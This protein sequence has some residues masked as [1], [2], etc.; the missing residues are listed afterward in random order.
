MSITPDRLEALAARLRPVFQKHT[1]LRAL[2]FGSWLAMKNRAGATSICWS[3][4]KQKNGS[5]TVTTTFWPRLPGL[6]RAGML[7]CSSIL[8]PS[9]PAWPI[10]LF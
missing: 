1:V 3:S 7:T 9:W 8:R 4:R 10:A 2:V 6:H 5:W